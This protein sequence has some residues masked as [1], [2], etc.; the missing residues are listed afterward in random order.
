MLEEDRIREMAEPACGLPL[1][2]TTASQLALLG[3][4]TAEDDVVDSFG[5]LV[6]TVSKLG[7][8]RPLATADSAAMSGIVG[9]LAVLTA[10]SAGKNPRPV[11]LV[12][13]TALAGSPGDRPGRFHFAPVRSTGSASAV[14]PCCR[15]L[16]RR[17]GGLQGPATC[18]RLTVLTA[19]SNSDEVVLVTEGESFWTA[20]AAA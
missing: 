12:A 8:D 10:G 17:R 13:S 18:C 1:L 15:V 9:R 2:E 5:C 3:L 4:T 20:G 16:G 6:V 19:S 7:A 14:P 11:G